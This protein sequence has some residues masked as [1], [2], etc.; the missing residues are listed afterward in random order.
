MKGKRITSV[1]PLEGALDFF[2]TM[3]LADRSEAI[4]DKIG[5]ITID[6]CVPSDTNIWETGIKRESVEGKW[7]IV[8]QY[9]TEEEAK[10]GHKGWVRLMR[11]KPTCKLIDID[12][13]NLGENAD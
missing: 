3:S 1:S 8:S 2:R 10:K 6:T 12:M 4:T 7:V 9:E 11:E 13:W 5:D